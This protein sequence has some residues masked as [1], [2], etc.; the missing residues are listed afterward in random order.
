VQQSRVRGDTSAGV[1][2]ARFTLQLTL[3][4]VPELCLMTLKPAVLL[5]KLVGALSYS[6][7]SLIGVLFHITV[8]P[9][10]RSRKIRCA[11]WLIDVIHDV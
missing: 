9:M 8:L 1:A 6:V 10:F 2:S 4:L 3:R 5:P 7:L 11:S